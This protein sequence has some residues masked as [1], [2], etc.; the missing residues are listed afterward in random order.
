MQFD[1][2][3][4]GPEYNIEGPAKEVPQKNLHRPDLLLFIKKRHKTVLEL[5]VFH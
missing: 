4:A 2:A 1:C 5:H 3:A